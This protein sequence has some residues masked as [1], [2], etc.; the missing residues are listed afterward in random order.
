MFTRDFRNSSRNPDRPY[1]LFEGWA[2]AA[3]FLNDLM[4]P[5][6]AEFPLLDIFLQT[7]S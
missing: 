5:H 3:C 6:Q 4:R 2:G 7:I 1:S